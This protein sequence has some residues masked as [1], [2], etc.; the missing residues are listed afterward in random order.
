MRL[1][2]LGIALVVAS[3]L[4]GLALGGLDPV[5]DAADRLDPTAPVLLEAARSPLA[6]RRIKAAEAFGRIQR[7]ACVD[8]LLALL[9][10]RSPRVREA[11]L[12]A[13]GQ[14]GWK[15]EFSGGREAPIASA[16]ARFLDRGD[17]GVRLAA[18]EAIGKVAMER[19]PELLAPLLTGRDAAIRTEALLGL[20]RYRFVLWLRSGKAPAPLPQAVLD[21]MRPLRQDRSPEVRRALLYAFTRFKDPRTLELLTALLR[22][23]DEWTRFYCLVGLTKLADPSSAVGAREALAD[24]SPHVRL[25]A[26]RALA[27]M[28]RGEAAAPA[29]ADGDLHVRAGVATALAGASESAG[30]DVAGWLRELAGD[31]RS[32]VRAAAVQALATRFKEGATEDVRRS[33]HD[34][35]EAVRAA[36][37]GALKALPAGDRA[38]LLPIALADPAVAVRCA[39]LELVASDPGAEA[40][41]LVERKLSS[42]QA[43]ERGA[44]VKAL[45]SRE[46][47]RALDLA[48]LAYQ[49]NAGMRLGALR[50]AAIEAF[51][52]FK[53]EKSDGYLRQALADPSSPVAMAAYRVLV[54]RGATDVVAP[55]E[56]LTYSPYRDLAVPA[57]PVLTLTTTKGPVVIALYRDLAPVH[58]ANAVGLVRAGFFDG[59]TWQRV[60]ANFV[61]QGGAPSPIGWE[62][63]EWLLRAE[64]NRVRF[65]RGAVGMSRGELFNSGDSEFFVDHVPAPHL[66]GQYTCFGQ[67]IAGMSAVDRIEPGDLIIAAREG[68]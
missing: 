63:Q 42:E 37:V 20:T 19:A 26:V 40:L 9:R 43:D 22:D 8:P 49:S 30:G 45:A 4:P 65:G 51:A 15:A 64:V 39:V 46:E 28:G 50:D 61:I 16:V 10:D 18:V 36:G 1:K 44:A 58:V 14:F 29:R 32:E 57:R 35:S 56:T 34:P 59:K 17:R 31:P 66:D 53:G 5:T 54:G 13:L 27:A 68:R 52:A 55:L 2:M 23:R 24:R 33:L 67:V 12:F 6:S 38:T 48:W 11:A 41:A 21:R 47:P 3:L 25:A 7:P 60:V 62:G